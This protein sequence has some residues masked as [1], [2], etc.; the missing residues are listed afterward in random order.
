VIRNRDIPA[1]TDRRYTRG[2]WVLSV[3]VALLLAALYLRP[4]FFSRP[5]AQAAFDAVGKAGVVESQ[6]QT[7]NK[8]APGGS[9]QW[10]RVRLDDGRVVDAVTAQPP[11]LREGN[12]VVL[13]GTSAGPFPY[14]A[15]LESGN[16]KR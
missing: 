11:L 8:W 10:L 12:R 5:A 15:V 2:A 13:R 16:A 1:E 7:Q 4:I 14:E 3:L 9:W 6:G